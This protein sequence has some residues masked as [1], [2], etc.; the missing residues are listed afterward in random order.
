LQKPSYTAR[1][2][3][4]VF[5]RDSNDDVPSTHKKSHSRFNTT[6]IAQQKKS[7]AHGNRKRERERERETN[8]CIKNVK[9][10]NEVAGLGNLNECPR[11]QFT[12]AGI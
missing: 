3:S 9:R 5:T 10:D 12:A 11:E 4:K 1:T 6:F 7:N 8:D 2:E